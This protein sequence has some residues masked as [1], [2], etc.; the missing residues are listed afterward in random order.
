VRLEL[1]RRTD[2]ALRALHVLAGGPARQKAAEVAEK[3]GS[4]RSFVPQVVGPLVERGWVSSEPGPTGGYS[5]AT[6]LDEV[7]MLDLIETSEGPTDTGRCV[8][9]DQDCPTARRCALHE[10]WTRARRAL[11]AELAATAVS[12]VPPG[13]APS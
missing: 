13:E 1:T 8:L 5:L 3:I 7:S 12:S 11:M 4:T 2:L 6:C 9:V 10:P